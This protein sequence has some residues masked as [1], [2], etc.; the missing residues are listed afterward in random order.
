[1]PVARIRILMCAAVLIS[2]GGC[3]R[4]KMTEV[5]VGEHNFRVPEAHLVDDE[6]RSAAARGHL[7]FVINPEAPPEEQMLVGVDPSQ[8]TCEPKHS[9]T[10]NM[11]SKACGASLT[12]RDK[13]VGREFE[14]E[15]VFPRESRT[16][17]EYRV[18]N[19]EDGYDTVAGCYALSNGRGLCRSIGNYKDLIYSVGFRDSEISNLPQIWAKAQDLLSSWEVTSENNS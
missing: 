14:P 18:H 3:D 5:Q 13:Q 11:L 1:M 17:W 12:E 2:I 19:D 8:G 9:P 16:H 4:A 10:S 7:R 15:K 6:A